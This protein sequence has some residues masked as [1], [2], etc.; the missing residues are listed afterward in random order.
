MKTPTDLD[1]LRTAP[2]GHLAAVAETRRLPL[3]GVPNGATS[4]V[5]LEEL[6]RRLFHAPSVL[7]ALRGL[8]QGQWAILRELA[9]CGGQAPSLV[10]RFYLLAAGMLPGAGRAPDAQTRLFELTLGR[11]LALGL[12]FWGRL[13]V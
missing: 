13:D 11:L 7:E 9:R 12:L 8:S 6:A 2:P 3:A 10:L 1:V 4:N 5:A